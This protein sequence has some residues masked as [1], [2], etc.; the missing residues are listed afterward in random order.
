MFCSRRATGTAVSVT[1]GVR[2]LVDICALWPAPALPSVECFSARRLTRS[3]TRHTHNAYAIGVME[4]GVGVSDYRGAIHRFPAGSI[5][6]MNPDEPHTGRAEDG[7]GLTYRMFYIKPDALACLAPS[8]RVPRF[9]TAC[10]RNPTLASALAGAH[11]ALER[12][13]ALAG[14]VQLSDALVSLIE[15]YGSSPVP[16]A[17]SAEPAAIA[18]VK[19]YLR[20]HYA[21]PVGLPELAAVAGLSEAHL[22][23]AFRRAAG[24]PPHAWLLQ[25]RIELARDR[26]VA[27]ASIA[28]VAAGLGFA[29]QSHFTRRFRKLTGMTPAQFIAGQDRS[30]QA[31][32]HPVALPACPSPMSRTSA[33]T[34]PKSMSRGRVRH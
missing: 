10:I 19:D 27:G 33:G 9:L 29:D 4:S 31:A 18:R 21:R 8:A 20:A 28:D 34:S 7:R 24:V 11:C 30:I 5:V 17:T 12:G 14:Q 26:L 2:G 15:Q 1:C 16:A 6:G 32:A 3:Y 13:D 25:L 23:R 22:I